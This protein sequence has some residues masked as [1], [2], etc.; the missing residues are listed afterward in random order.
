MDEVVAGRNDASKIL[1]KDNDTE[2]TVSW[3]S[4]QVYIFEWLSKRIFRRA[5]EPANPT[6]A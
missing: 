1:R 3:L 4:V 5:N 6:D 2:I